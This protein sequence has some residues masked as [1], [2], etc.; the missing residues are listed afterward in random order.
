[1]KSKLMIWMAVVAA[2]MMPGR[3]AENQDAAKAD[4]AQAIV[5]R[6]GEGT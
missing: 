5:A 1:M 6:Q 2:M 3:A 4:V